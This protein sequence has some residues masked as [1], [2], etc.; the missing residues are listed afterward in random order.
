MM[1]LEFR[2]RDDQIGF[3]GGL[4]KEELLKPAVAG[5]VHKRPGIAVIEIEE[6][7]AGSPQG[8]VEP[9]FDQGHF[10]IADVPR[11]FSNGNLRAHPRKTSAAATTTAGW[12]V[13]CGD[14]RVGSTRLGLRSTRRPRTI[15]GS[16]PTS[17]SP[18]RMVSAKG[19]S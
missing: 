13:A 6:G 18:R 17:S 8:V 10:A 5:M 7:Q 14:S 1:R 11:A 16:N 4:R 9:G 3:Q 2:Q 12:V 15:A 19:P